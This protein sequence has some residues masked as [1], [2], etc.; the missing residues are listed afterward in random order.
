MGRVTLDL[1]DAESAV[2][3]R[4]L[5]LYEARITLLRAEGEADDYPDLPLVEALIARFPHERRS[6]EGPTQLRIREECA[7]L[8]DFL[9]E[10][11]QAYGDS[12]LDP[13]QVFTRPLGIADRRTRSIAGLRHRIDDKL[14]RLSRGGEYQGDDDLLDLVG[15]LILLRIAEVDSDGHE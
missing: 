3:R 2:L 14:S 9:V 11:N 15:Y 8:A 6:A 1:S 12:A 5:V 4:A 13:V 7:R 10:K